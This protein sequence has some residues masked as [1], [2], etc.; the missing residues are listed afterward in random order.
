MISVPRWLGKWLCCVERSL[1][2]LMAYRT[3]FVNVYYKN[4]I[5][6]RFTMMNLYMA[7]GG[8][9]W[10]YLSTPVVYTS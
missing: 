5:A 4:N 9:N 6:Q 7:F 1:N 10:G 2:L 3:S 8:T